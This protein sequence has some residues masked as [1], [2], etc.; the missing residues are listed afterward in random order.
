M[1]QEIEICF[2]KHG[3]VQWEMSGVVSKS[4]ED[5]HELG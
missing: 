4:F 1:S 3:I 5:V 2:G